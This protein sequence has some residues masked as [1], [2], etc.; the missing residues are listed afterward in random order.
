[1]SKIRTLSRSFA[2]G[3]L[4]P[5]LQGRIDLDKYQTGLAL[6]E[7]FIPLAHG[8][9]QARPGFRYVNEVK[10][11]NQIVR[12]IPFVF[13]SDETMVLEMG[14]GYFRFHTNGASLIEPTKPI[15]SIAGSTVNVTAHGYSV[16]QWVYIGGRYYRVATVPN[17]NSFTV[18][19]LDGTT[20]APSGT[21]AARLYEISNVYTANQ[22]FDVHYV[23]SNDVITFVHPSHPVK[24]LS[25]T[26]TYSWVFASE[27]FSPLLD[28]PTGINSTKQMN[29][30]TDNFREYDY[31]V[32]ALD[33]TGIN[34]SEASATTNEQNNLT[35]FNNLNIIT[36]DAVTGAERYNVYRVK[37]GTPGYIGQTSA[38]SFTDDNIVPDMNKTPPSWSSPFNAADKYPSA[39][40]YFD[41]R[42]VFASTNESP[43]SVFM[44]RPA[45]E[46]NFSTSFPTIDNDPITFEIQSLNQNRIRHLIPLADLVALTSGGEYRIYNGSGEPVTPATVMARPQ[47]YVGANNVQPVVTAT[48]ALYVQSQGSRIR[49]L[50]YDS[51]GS[52][53]YNSEDISV[54]VP[55]LFNGYE[56]VD[57]AYSRGPISTMYAARNDGTLL[58][59]TYE[60]TQQ[61]RAWHRHTTDGVF[62]SVA[63]VPE[64]NEDVLY[65]VVRREVNGRSVR[66]IE[67]MDSPVLR[68]TLLSNLQTIAIE[69]FRVD[70]GLTYRGAPATVIS[71][72]WHLEGKTVSILA[73]GAVMPRATV[74]NGTVTLTEPASVVHV[75]LQITSQMTTLPVTFDESAA[76]Q[77]LPKNVVKVHLRVFS[78]SGIF[79]GPNI[80]Q[81]REYKQRT[82]E[83]YGQPPALTTGI[84]E[85][86]LTARWGQDGSITIAQI[87]PLPL[88]VQA[89]VLEVAVGG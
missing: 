84:V 6:C 42:K 41:Q 56:V 19:N 9:A 79:V 67:R 15:T 78:S 54:L 76:G 31:C 5:E 69:A 4:A 1:M 11:S 58:G 40:S 59:L 26:S 70:S 77:G 71:G 86:P 43:Q 14:V 88:S 85:V 74:V 68:P 38:L 34:E 87:D 53:G 62:E 16:G 20:G 13:S 30:G 3:E 63:C 55:H 57:L 23:Q 10:N 35:Q 32:T 47:S 25:R 22:L 8:P 83:P 18:N 29:G 52:G 24:T 49:E 37:S 81:L 7:N 60:P 45:T 73:D 46:T 17:A 72:L 21:T 36:W 66:Y 33:Q 28:A 64:D 27:D 51:Q 61:V 12:L 89:A 48:S 75:G 50:T 82:T 39:V 65:A 2:G 44:T 80:F